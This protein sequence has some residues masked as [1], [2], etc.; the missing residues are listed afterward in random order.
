RSGPDRSGAGRSAA[1]RRRRGRE[2]P[3]AE[4]VLDG[5][6]RAEH[7]V[8][9]RVWSIPVTGFWQAHRSAPAAYARTVAEFVASSARPDPHVCWDLYGGAGV[10]AGALADT[11]GAA[12]IHIVDSAAAA[13]AA[14]DD[15]FADDQ[16]VRTHGGE[17]AAV[18]PDLPSPDVVILDPPR[19]GAGERVIDRIVAA[20][21][22]VVVHVGCDI[23]R[24]ARDLALF[25]AR[26]Y[27]VTTLR[28]FD[29]F[30]LTHHV[31]VIAALTRVDS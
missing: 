31:E 6:R 20:G 15:V 9:E 25:T 26:G 30:P 11:T 8:G 22:E 4:H 28:A 10:F 3:R 21:P 17:V 14:A 29:A 13:L 18:I 16:R 27:R 24:F 1:Q 12:E 19:T 2:A 7:R 23:A 5:G